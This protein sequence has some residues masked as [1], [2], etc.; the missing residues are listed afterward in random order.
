MAEPHHVVPEHAMY[1]I[2]HGETEWSTTGRHTGRTDIPLTERGEAQARAAGRVLGLLR[3]DE[4]GAPLI[5]SSPRARAERTA[6]LAGIP[7]TSL[8]EQL[9]EWDYGD[10]EGRTTEQIRQEVPGWTIWTHPVPG[11]ETA[12]TVGARASLLLDTVHEA[13]AS[14]DVV[15]VGH[16]HFSRVL[17]SRWL[18][19]PASA[20]VRFA[21]DPAAVSVLGYERGEPQLHRLNVPPG[22][23][24]LGTTGGHHG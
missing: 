7:P 22:E 15:L 17:I 21:L 5:L 16:G 20:G 8:T 24:G 3:G 9:S 18:G 13:L 6:E 2:R 11:G 23:A 10:Y 1:L 14:R 19:M 4:S 12:E